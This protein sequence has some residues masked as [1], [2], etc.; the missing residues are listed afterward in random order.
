MATKPE[1]LDSL[2]TADETTDFDK[3]LARVLS[4]AAERI[5][6]SVEHA[7]QLGIIDA[8]GNLI[9]KDL[10]KDMQPGAQRDFGG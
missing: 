1:V 8:T 5:H 6:A 4:G 9:S 10:P 7:Q 3:V 2:P